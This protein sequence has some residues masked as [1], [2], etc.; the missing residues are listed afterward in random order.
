MKVT[1]LRE[2]HG[3]RVVTMATATPIANS[4]TEAHVM[5]RYLRPDLLQAAGVEHFDQWAATFGEAIT[6]IEMAPTGGGNYRLQTRFSRFA[7]VPEM[8][9]MWHVFADV[10]T[11]EDLNLPVPSLRPYATRT[12]V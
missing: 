9:R 2:R 6:E 5:Q 12:A 7:N 3:R 11:G 4:V 10:K 8:L 1:W